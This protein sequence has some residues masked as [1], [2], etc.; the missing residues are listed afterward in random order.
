MKKYLSVAILV[1]GLV[2]AN[3]ASAAVI[4]DVELF[5]ESFTFG[6]D[7]FSTQNGFAGTNA[8]AGQIQLTTNQGS[9]V[10]A[11]CIDL[12]HDVYLGAGQNLNYVGQ[13]L[14]GAS[15]GDGGVL[16]A[17]Q[18]QEIGGLV[19]Y[20]NHLIAAGGATT[21]QAA[22]IQMAIWATEYSG[23][24]FA[25]P[26]QALADEQS[27]LAL[28]PSLYGNVESLVSDTGTQELAAE[29][30]Q[31]PEPASMSLLGAGLFGLGMLRRR[32]ATLA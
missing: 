19:T 24:T 15:N 10:D 18:A 7:A 22:G 30:N 16:S 4:N 2:S 28:A 23:L 5:G 20:G 25:A 11:W 29:T 1:A 8:L 21:D 6:N 3:T 9:V 31:I 32:T 17:L 13:S 14:T 12:F 27:Y 26:S